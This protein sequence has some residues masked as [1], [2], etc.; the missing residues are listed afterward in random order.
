MR[1]VYFGG[2]L[3]KRKGERWGSRLLNSAAGIVQLAKCTGLP[4][5]VSFEESI[6][7]LK[8]VLNSSSECKPIGS[9]L[10]W[11]YDGG[12]RDRWKIWRKHEN[13]AGICD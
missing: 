12:Q 6:V 2:H 1:L 8:E 11:Q 10:G 3:Q 4:L 13:L 7:S 5:D 9:D